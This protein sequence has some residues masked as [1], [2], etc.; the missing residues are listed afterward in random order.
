MEQQRK[1][2]LAGAL[3]QWRDWFM[4]ERRCSPHTLTAY[5][6]DLSAFFAFLAQRHGVEPGLDALR[7][8]THQ[9]FRA[10][11]AHRSADNGARSSTNRA[12]SCIRGFYRFLARREIIKNGAIETVRG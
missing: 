10:Y 2:D 11:L 7:G 5:D 3:A 9:D 1:P 12:V 6:G 4:V 8:L